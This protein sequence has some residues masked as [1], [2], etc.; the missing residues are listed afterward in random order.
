MAHN[1]QVVNHPVV[2]TKLSQLRNTQTT[3]KD[4]REVLK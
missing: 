2:Q 3:P 1:V 4:F